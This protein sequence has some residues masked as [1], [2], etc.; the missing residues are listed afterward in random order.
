MNR[1]NFKNVKFVGSLNF[2]PKV[3]VNLKHNTGYTG[4]RTDEL[5][6]NTIPD[7]YGDYE[8]DGSL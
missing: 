6:L 1:G 5:N 2:K 4:I 3:R 7:S 8:Q